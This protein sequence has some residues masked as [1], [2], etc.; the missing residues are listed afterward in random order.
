MSSDLEEGDF[1]MDEALRRGASVIAMADIDHPDGRN[2][3]WT[4][5]GDLQYGGIV[6]QGLQGAL[7]RITPAAVSTSI[8]IRQITLELAGVP[9][10]STKYLSAR[11]RGREAKVWLAAMRRNRIVGARDLI[12]DS[13]LD[14]QKLSIG[15]DGLATIQ[16]IGNV[17]FWLAER[18]TNKAWTHEQQQILYPG[19]TGMSLMPELANKDVRWRLS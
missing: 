13:I 4:G 17:G 15:D 16:L 19:D 14:Y 11:V 8:A 5:V 9:P 10:V 12:I 1:F 3:L 7:A 6:W 18:A 2:Y